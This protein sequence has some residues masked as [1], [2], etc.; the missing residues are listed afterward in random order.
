M[1]TKVDRAKDE[2]DF[3]LHVADSTTKPDLTPSNGPQEVE[4]PSSFL[5][6]HIVANHSSDEE[7]SSVSQVGLNESAGSSSVSSLP[8]LSTT[9]IV[10][11]DLATSGESS[12]TTEPMLTVRSNAGQAKGTP[13]PSVMEYGSSDM[14]QVGTLEETLKSAMH[15][16][17]VLL[18]HPSQEDIHIEQA[19][20]ISGINDDDI[21][22]TQ[23]VLSLTSASLMGNQM[24]E[25]SQE[26][27]DD[28][29]EN[30]EHEVEDDLLPQGP[31]LIP[32]SFN[33]S[34]LIN[35]KSRRDNHLTD[36]EYNSSDWPQPR[37]RLMAYSAFTS[38]SGGYI[39]TGMATPHRVGSTPTGESGRQ[40]SVIREPPAGENDDCGQSLADF[41]DRPMDVKRG[42]QHRWKHG[43]NRIGSG[44][45]F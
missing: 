17:Q 7:S 34:P 32:D 16:T 10:T 40:L 4:D 26:S 20:T 14:S 3:E 37:G 6:V 15:V 11:E 43:P 13:T 25:K 33:L 29:Q 45:N 28:T 35:R 30:G 39:K 31:P 5:T 2:A 24:V 21:K 1:D 27:T 12:V 42:S 44:G 8:S 23:A 41:I 9:P 18:G 36:E 38:D 22:S 19:P